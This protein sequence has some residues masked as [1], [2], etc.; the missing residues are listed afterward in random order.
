MSARRSVRGPALGLGIALGLVLALVL[1]FEGRG[2]GVALPL[3]RRAPPPSPWPA[4]PVEPAPDWPTYVGNGFTLRHPPDAAA[5]PASDDRLDA[6]T[7]AIEG[8][9]VQTPRGVGGP[10]YHLLVADHPNPGRLTTAAWAD[11]VRA[12]LNDREIG[13][14]SLEFVPTADTALLV[15]GAPALRLH[16][17]DGRGE[18]QLIFLA[19]PRRAVT[20]RIVYGRETPGDRNAQRRLYEAIIG[21]LRWTP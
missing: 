6:S 19:S 12:T 2:L 8:P 16:P 15:D 4:L 20:F 13:P 14:D 3:A 5:E 7:V 18:T 17:W 1:A 11:S 9:P 21:T 10:A